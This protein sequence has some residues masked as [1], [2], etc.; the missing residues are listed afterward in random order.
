MKYQIIFL[1]GALILIQL[2]GCASFSSQEPL[3]EQEQDQE[4]DQASA[5]SPALAQQNNWNITGKLGI[6]TPQK[7]QSINLIWQQK[8]NNFN[9]KLNGPIGFGAA[10]IKGNQQQLTI[11]KGSRELIKTPEQLGTSLLGVPLSVDAMSWWVKGL[12]SPNHNQAS[13]INFRDDG[14]ISSFQQNGWQL[15]FSGYLAN[16]AYTIPKKISGRH[17]DVSFKLVINEWQFFTQ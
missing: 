7:A 14:L 11:Q 2:S 15:N 4:P 10:T 12:I 6:R 8:N 16:G 5:Q 1:L 17:G 9:I 13:N 3:Q